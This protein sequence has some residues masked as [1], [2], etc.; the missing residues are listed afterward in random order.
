[1]SSSGSLQDLHMLLSL[2]VLNSFSEVVLTEPSIARILYNVRNENQLDSCQN[3][4]YY[5]GIW[6]VRIKR[7]VDGII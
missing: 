1:M 5:R 7:V 6:S 3:Q 2:L 4:P